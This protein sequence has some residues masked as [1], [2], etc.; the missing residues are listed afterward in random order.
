[1]YYYVVYDSFNLICFSFE[2]AVKKNN[3]KT[4]FK[5]VLFI[6]YNK[7]KALVFWS[8]SVVR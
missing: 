3:V 6:S 2:P 7:H 1:M 5:A 8:V 4:Y